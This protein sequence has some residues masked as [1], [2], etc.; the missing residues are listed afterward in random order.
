MILT[1][2][3]VSNKTCTHTY[4]NIILRDCVT[5]ILYDHRGHCGDACS[6]RGQRPGCHGNRASGHRNRERG[7]KG[8]RRRRR[9]STEP[10]HLNNK[11]SASILSLLC[12]Y[13]SFCTHKHTHVHPGEGSPNT[14]TSVS[15]TPSVS[16]S[17]GDG[18]SQKLL[19]S[20]HVTVMTTFS[21]SSNGSSQSLF[22]KILCRD[23][24]IRETDPRMMERGMN[25]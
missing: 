1:L 23:D 11:I 10:S 14:T 17:R 4:C 21:T 19:S 25:H 9:G 8:H 24:K 20:L 3:H 13:I 15:L 16:Q 2:I 7:M 18:R 12:S 6:R 22:T 5:E